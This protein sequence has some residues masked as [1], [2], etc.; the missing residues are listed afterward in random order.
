MS[1]N[2]SPPYGRLSSFYFFYFA[3]LGILVPYWGLYLQFLNFSPR[4]IGELL[5]I[6]VGTKLVAPYLWGWIADHTGK[7]IR[8]VQIG[9]LLA[10]ICFLLVYRV[11][12]YWGMAGAMMLYSFF[13]NAVL[14]QYE[15]T[16]MNHLGKDHHRYSVLR[17]WGS[18][19]FI[20]SVLLL[21][22]MIDREGAGIIVPFLVLTFAM[23]WVSAMFTPADNGQLHADEHVVEK[24]FHIIRRPEVI[25]LFAVCFLMQFSHGPY[26]AFY[27]IYM[28]GHG[29]SKTIIG[30]FWALG[31]IAEV[32][33]FL[34]M[35]RLIVKYGPRLLLIFSLVV[36]VIRWL[37]IAIWPQEWWL[38]VIAQTFHAATF[39]MYHAI[40]IYLI[41]HYFTGKMQGRGQALYS[42]ISFGA[43]GAL[44]SLVSGYTWDAIGG[45]GTYMIAS[46]GVVIAVAI[47]LTG[48]RDT[49][50]HKL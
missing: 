5:A 43:G 3:T 33:V 31:V 4:E 14:P 34:V 20:V 6:L 24:I 18:I 23:I 35:S 48:V 12:G 16:T 8:I 10:A 15:A 44:G 25:S 21:G 9:S 40:A 50:S 39:G 26:Y 37:M 30:Q 36:A 38:M 46:A 7:R 17:S 11:S 19:G 45:A 2:A 42:S 1:R 32:F 22:P 28:E 49:V 29:Y 41:H 27:S 47:A 13:W